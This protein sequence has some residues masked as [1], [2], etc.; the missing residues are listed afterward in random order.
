MESVLNQIDK[1]EFWDQPWQNAQT[2]IRNS[3]S[4]ENPG[5]MEF[6]KC[7]FTHA[8][9]AAQTSENT[10]KLEDTVSP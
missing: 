1:K 5:P 4:L 2:A 10:P 9:T 8:I 3:S 6:S 7:K